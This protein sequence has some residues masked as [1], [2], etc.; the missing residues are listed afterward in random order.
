MMMIKVVCV[1]C[2]G[3]KWIQSAKS[4][5]L[6]H[7]FDLLNENMIAFMS[8]WFLEVAEDGC[9]SKWT[10]QVV[11][12]LIYIVYCFSVKHYSKTIHVVGWLPAAAE[13]FLCVIA[14][15]IPL[16]GELSLSALLIMWILW[17]RKRLQFHSHLFFSLMSNLWHIKTKPLLAFRL[18]QL[19]INGYRST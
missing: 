12:W 6:M 18:H 13:F 17:Q 11:L 5:R 15:L 1:R 10:T 8:L 4:I 14:G 3:Q 2:S 16:L 19:L 7:L 9:K